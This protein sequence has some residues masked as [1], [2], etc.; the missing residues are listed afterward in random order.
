MNDI[1][2][3][4]M[5]N[6]KNVKDNLVSVI[7]KIGEKI[8][9]R[10]CDFIESNKFVNFSYTHSAIKK[11]IGKIGVLLS[12]KTNK[13]KDEILDFGKQLS[14]HIAASSPLT[15]DKDTLDQSLLKKEKEIITEEL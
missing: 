8:S 1:L 2:V 12:L 3:A 9:L 11:N 10:R 5:E 6:K 13:K 14:M 15:I 4:K 7:S